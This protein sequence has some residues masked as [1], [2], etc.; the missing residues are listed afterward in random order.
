MD[1]QQV[2]DKILTEATA[3]AEAIKKQTREKAE[4]AKSALE[5]EIAEFE[6]QTR[7]LS[8]QAAEDKKAHMLAA[9][10]MQIS[11]DLLAEKRAIL[12]SVFEQAKQAVVKMPDEEYKTF[13]KN[14]MIK[15]VE[16]GDEQVIIDTLESRIDQSL[17][18]EVNQKLKSDSDGR[19]K[20]SEQT[21]DISAGFILKRGPI[22]IN[23]SLE[24]LFTQAR[25]ELEI[26]LAKQL[27]E[28]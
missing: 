4:R 26:E 15:A 19:L 2:I 1:A 9:A 10:R 7:V 25:D 12:E 3:Q 14:L 28:D 21:E 22:M 8:E 6:E 18:D 13:I 17:I 24:A 20:L 11:K 5:D 16:T 23:A 27:F